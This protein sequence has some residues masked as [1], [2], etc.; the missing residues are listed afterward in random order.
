M[1]IKKFKFKTGLLLFAIHIRG[2]DE[3]F[4]QF[5]S[6]CYFLYTLPLKYSFPSQVSNRSRL[7]IVCM[8]LDLK[9]VNNLTIVSVCNF[10]MFFWLLPVCF[11]CRLYKINLIFSCLF[12]TVYQ[13][14][15]ILYDVY[16]YWAKTRNTNIMFYLKNRI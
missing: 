6:V 5:H 10:H 16:K 2:K 12:D 3:C 9:L 11:I 8:C 7:Q 15:T 13:N 4:P 14:Q 1:W